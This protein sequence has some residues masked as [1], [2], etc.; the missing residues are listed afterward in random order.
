MLSYKG[1][2]S[3]PLRILVVDDNIDAA[4]LT[5]SLLRHLG[6]DVR[7]EYSAE[8]ALEQAEVDIFDFC[9]LD[10][11]LP[12]MDGYELAAKLREK[13]NTQTA[14]FAALTGYGS[15]TYI[16]KSEEQGFSYHFV[17]PVP[18]P[19]LFDACAEISKKIKNKL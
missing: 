1:D 3:N 16:N 7:I 17:K 11:G 5:G 18:I 13:P 19:K 2:Q 4:T 15:E 14:V 6:Y 10:I 12:G 9:L 8:A